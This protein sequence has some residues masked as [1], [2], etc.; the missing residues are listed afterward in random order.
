MEKQSTTNINKLSSNFISELFK[1][2][3]IYSN[4]LEI[5]IDYVKYHYLET[6]AQKKVFKYI[7]DT[8]GTLS[9]VPTIGTIAQ[10]FN[11]EK[12]VL[13]FLNEVKNTDISKKETELLLDQLESFIKNSRFIETYNT[14]HDLYQEGKRE[15]AISYMAD[16]SSSINNFL[17]KKNYY[18]TVFGDYIERDNK[19]VNKLR[20][21]QELKSKIPSGIRELDEI[22]YGG[23]RRG[24]SALFLGQSGYG[25]STALKWFGISA[26]R[27]GHIVVHFQIEGSEEECMEG[28][29][30]AWTATRLT[31]FD[32]LDYGDLDQKTK[33]LIEKARKDIVEIH[34]G[35]IFIYAEESF[36]S[37]TPEKAREVL[38]D[39]QR[40]QGRVDLIIFDYLE[41]M[42]TSKFYKDERKRREKLANQITSLAIE[43]NAASLTATQAQDINPELMLK[44]DFVMSR[45]HISEFKGCLKPFSYFITLNATPDEYRND[46]MRLY[47][48]KFRRYRSGQT[49]TIAQKKDIGR[50]YESQRTLRD[51]Y[52]EK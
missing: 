38:K 27:T 1:S 41:V 17:L 46:V 52:K 21:N 22:I 8:Y 13:S 20:E 30:A 6:D 48:D 31:D 32:S 23:W 12:D 49:I 16:Q 39:V 50:F 24:T 25:K 3:L 18:K 5:C 34:G 10:N 44:E 42:E 4:V 35:E 36:E 14:V 40:I 29:D 19:R 43:F 33:D 37:L 9:Q 28:Y 47:C 26:A 11:E 51:F 7:Y 15:E 45:H 2:C